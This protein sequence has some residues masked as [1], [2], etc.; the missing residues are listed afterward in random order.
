MVMEVECV[1][2]V[3]VWLLVFLHPADQTLNSCSSL[4]SDLF[5]TDYTDEHGY[6]EEF[7]IKIDHP[8]IIYL[9]V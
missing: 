6:L 5:A 7:K 3:A 1:V 2:A 4:R 9:K 8:E